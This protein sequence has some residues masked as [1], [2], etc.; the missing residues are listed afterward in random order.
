MRACVCVVTIFQIFLSE[1]KKVQESEQNKLDALPVSGAYFP[2]DYIPK[3]TRDTAKRQ[4][5][6]V[7]QGVQ[8]QGATQKLGRI[9]E[10]KATKK[11]LPLCVV[12][13]VVFS[14]RLCVCVC[15]CLY[16]VRKCVRVYLFSYACVKSLPSPL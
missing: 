15:V 11:N 13:C 6:G 7:V 3:A 14:V 16:T 5:K 1:L 4:E 8:Q 2:F 9:Q 12:Q 10:E